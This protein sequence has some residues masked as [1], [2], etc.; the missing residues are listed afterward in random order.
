MNAQRLDAQSREGMDNLSQAVRTEGFSEFLGKFEDAHNLVD[1]E[2]NAGEI[3]RR[4]EVFQKLPDVIRTV[5]QLA[6]EKNFQ[7]LGRTFTEEELKGIDEELE[8]KIFKEKDFNIIYTL[9]RQVAKYRELP[10]KIMELEFTLSGLGDKDNLDRQAVNL[11]YKIAEKEGGI[12]QAEGSLEGMALAKE[13]VGVVQKLEKTLDLAEQVFMR[14]A[15]VVAHNYQSSL[16]QLESAQ[17]RLKAADEKSPNPG[18]LRLPDTFALKRTLSGLEK[19]KKN[20]AEYLEALASL[21]FSSSLESLRKDMRLAS[22]G[23]IGILGK[24][25]G[26]PKEAAKYPNLQESIAEF[27]AVRD[28]LTAINIDILWDRQAEDAESDLGQVVGIRQGLSYL[29][30]DPG[31]RSMRFTVEDSIREFSTSTGKQLASGL[32]FGLVELAGIQESLERTPVTDAEARSAAIFSGKGFMR[33][34]VSRNPENTLAKQVAK[35]VDSKTVMEEERERILLQIQSVDSAESALERRKDEFKKTKQSLFGTLKSFDGLFKK[36]RKDAELSI[37]NQ[38]DSENLNEALAA[39]GAIEKLL[40]ARGED[41]ELYGDLDSDDEYDISLYGNRNLRDLQNSYKEILTTKVELAVRKAVE[42]LDVKKIN[43]DSLASKLKEFE[44]GLGSLANTQQYQQ[45]R[46]L[47][48]RQLGSRESI[49]PVGKKIALNV[50]LYE[51]KK[52][53]F[54]S[55]G[56]LDLK[57]FVQ[58][59][60]I[61]AVA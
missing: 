56:V 22:E 54:M 11:N 47:A 57:G 41:P 12:R 8:A 30:R 18:N 7:S 52:G 43:P 10:A 21:N 20:P 53:G 61:P 36:S 58:A 51:A 34:L 4:Y 24:I 28:N 55:G 26:K 50:M 14:E 49:L 29:Q 15:E 40:K 23:Q 17:G 37:N 48:L 3:L 2:A 9:S 25:L 13:G 59:S 46:L 44:D 33:R 31:N 45:V 42:T 16:A 32:K 19:K 39:K 1:I 27:R 35:D 60:V 5:R 38:L 6:I